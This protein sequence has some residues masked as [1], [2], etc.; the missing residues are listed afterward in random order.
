MRELLD[1]P[2]RALAAKRHRRAVQPAE[3][4]VRP[5][6]PP[7]AA[8]R[9]DEERRRHAADDADAAPVEE[10][11]E[12]RIRYVVEACDAGRR[13][14]G[15]PPRR[16]GRRHAGDPV[17]REAGG[18]RREHCGER[19]VRLA[20]EGEIDERVLPQERD[21]HRL[22]PVRPAE[23]DGQVRMLLLD[24]RGERERRD[25]L[26]E[27][28]REPDEGLLLPVD[29]GQAVVQ[30]R[31]DLRTGPPEPRDVQLRLAPGLHEHVVDVLRVRLGTPAVERLREQPVSGER[32]VRD[33]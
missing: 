9:L 1:D 5:L 29:G 28:R 18:A 30:E 21:A 19:L 3:R 14:R 12:V 23:G 16:S 8:R 33:G 11:V 26:L 10:R 31:L 4:A 20:G 7:A 13:R 25:V 15:A 32:R 27:D 6:A 2:L 22:L 24:P 17:D